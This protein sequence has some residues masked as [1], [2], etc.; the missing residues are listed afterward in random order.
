MLIYGAL[1]IPLI[2]VLIL[3]VFYKHQTT[4]WEFLI[5][6]SVSI[7]LIALMK[8]GI[9]T[10]MVK[11]DEYWGSVVYRVQYY[12]E[13]DEWI[14]QTCSS[15]CCCD[16]KGNNCQTT[17][18]DCSYREDHPAH[19]E[20]ITTTNETVHID[21]AEY[22]RIKK[23]MGGEK[24]TDLHHSYYIINGNEYSCTWNQ[25]KET[26][27][28]VTTLHSYKNK[29]K[30][31]DK[32][33]FHFQQVKDSDVVAYK[34]YSYPKIRNYYQMDAV[35]GD[36]TPDGEIANQKLQYLNGALGTKKQV[37]VFVL[38]F[39]NQPVTAGLLQESYWCGG[40]KNEF[41]VAIGT[42]KDR[43]VTWCYPF[44]W[45]K[46]EKLKIDVKNYVQSQK[47]L[48]LDSLA[49]YMLPQISGNFQRLHFKD[50]DYLTVEP[51]TGAV[52]AILLNMLLAIWI[53]ANGYG[54]D[55]SNSRARFHPY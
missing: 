38:L 46:S 34:L 9:E 17:Y 5:P 43:N 40:N 41:I 33:I 20:L 4:W 18:Y 25:S 10:A 21:E 1:L 50:F 24:F 7:I 16:S 47:K 6:V 28:P 44:S 54:D 8:L 51:S 19:W 22:N 39:P 12:E 11:S 35:L 23:I 52:V 26:T 13:W 45:T 55:E 3:F 48:S 42:D 31:A 37:R 15:T 14:T 2:V 36:N 53:V 49:D 29:V 30:V 27:V 32:S